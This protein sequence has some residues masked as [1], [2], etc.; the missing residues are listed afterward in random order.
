MFYICFMYVLYMYYIYSIRYMRQMI[1]IAK[2]LLFVFSKFSLPIDN[3]Q[4][5]INSLNNL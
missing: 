4:I 1:S 3:N 5:I 2:M